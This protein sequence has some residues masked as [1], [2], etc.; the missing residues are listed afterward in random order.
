MVVLIRIV[1]LVRV[2]Y[3]EKLIQII[4]RNVYV[5]ISTSKILR[6]FAKVATALV[7]LVMA[8]IRTIA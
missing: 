8:L 1:N 6:A 5:T 4:Q 3:L 2:C 7:P